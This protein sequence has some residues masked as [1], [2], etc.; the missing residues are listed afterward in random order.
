MLRNLNTNAIEKALS[1]ALPNAAEMKA[2]DH[3]AI[4]DGTPSIT[5]MERAARAVVSEIER[6]CPAQQCEKSAKKAATKVAILCGPGNNG[7]DGLA[8]GAILSSMSGYSVTVIASTPAKVTPEWRVMASRLKALLFF[9]DP[10]SALSPSFD[11]NTPLP[12]HQTLTEPECVEIIRRSDLVVDALLGIGQISAP[13]GPLGALANLCIKALASQNAEVDRAKVIAV[14]VP[15]GVCSDTGVVFTPHIKAHHTVAIELPKR[16]LLTYPA[17]EIAG[18]ITVIPIGICRSSSSQSVEFSL[19]SDR[20]ARATLLAHGYPLAPAI[21]KGA[22]GKVLIIGGCSRMPGAP[23]LA[24]LGA[25]RGGA[26]LVSVASLHHWGT[27]DYLPP[28]VMRLPLGISCDTPSEAQSD[29]FALRHAE[30]LMENLGNYSAVVL[31]PGLGGEPTTDP[32]ESVALSTFT[33]HVLTSCYQAAVPLVVDA[34]A[35]RS[36]PTDLYPESYEQLLVTPHPGE[37]AAML[38]TTSGEIQADRFSAVKKLRA[39]TGGTA[40]LKGASTLTYSST[41]PSRITSRGH[42]VAAGTPYLATAGSGDVLSGL[43]GALLAFG[44]P[45]HEAAP[46]GAFLHGQ[47]GEDAHAKH[48]N[49]IASDLAAALGVL[50][51]SLTEQGSEGKQD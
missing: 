5:L 44:V 50:L 37:A 34:S 22:R 23:A 15:T 39:V 25:L 1:I 8:V 4:A 2:L 47:A 11:T 28:E 14:D 9:P 45:A 26:G 20:D 42:L 7:G 13:R 32:G 21:H 33:S 36:I 31:G 49:L 17:R 16:G 10:P 6:L 27:F 51:P 30:I 12:S 24:A 40:L 18:E 41:A 43:L 35:L 19:Y 48:G 46:L 3:A 29:Y 38:S